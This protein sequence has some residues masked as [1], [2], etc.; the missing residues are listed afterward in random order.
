MT[1]TE[2]APLD[3]APTDEQEELRRTV[4]RF[5]GERSPE[6]EVRRVMD[7]PRGFDP[8]VWAGLCDIG[9]PGLAVPEEYGGMGGDYFALCL[10]L[11]ELA[12]VDQSVAI[13]LEAGVSLGA[14]PVYRFGSE[15]QKADW[16][17]LLASGQALGAFGLT[18][19]LVPVRIVCG[20]R[21]VTDERRSVG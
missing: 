17:P 20:S 5:L 2:T 15:Q 12:R 8:D 4:R 16:L 1:T 19:Q 7:T 10:A 13:T 18:E 14:M 21:V 11:E 9:V 6:S 3:L